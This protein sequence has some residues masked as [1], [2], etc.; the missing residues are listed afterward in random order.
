VGCNNSKWTDPVQIVNGNLIGVRYLNEIIQRHVLQL[1]QRQQNHITL[2]QDN[3]S[4]HV[5][6]V[7]RDCF[8]EKKVD[9]LLFPTVSLELSAIEYVWDVME[10]HLRCLLNQP[11]TFADLGQALT[12][13]WSNIPPAFLS[14][15]IASMRHPCQAC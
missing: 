3:A 7:A 9:V 5:A 1:I 14:T 13:I 12:N 2:P 11:V 15:S 8:V 6:S 4:P 10:Q